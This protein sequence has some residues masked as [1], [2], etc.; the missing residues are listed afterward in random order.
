MADIKELSEQ[1]TKL[2]ASIDERVTKANAT[3]ADAGK[4]AEDLKGELKNLVE[5]HNEVQRA[6]D[7]E[8][9]L[10]KKAVED[11]KAQL[12]EQQTQLNE[13][14]VRL[15]KA[16]KSKGKIDTLTKFNDA[17]ERE[18]NEKK[19]EIE[20]IRTIKGSVSLDIQDVTIKDIVS[21]STNTGLNSLLPSDRPTL[22]GP[23]RRTH[24]RDFMQ[25]GRTS[26]DSFPYIEE[27]A[28]NA[29][30]GFVGETE[31]P[32]KDDLQI[33]NKSAP[34]KK[35]V[36]TMDLSDEIIA[37]V[38]GMQTYAQGRMLQKYLLSEDAGI[39]KGAGTGNTLTGLF[40]R[41][42]AFAKVGDDIAGATRLDIL[43]KAVAL[44]ANREY[45]ATRALIHDVD[46]IDMG[47]MKDDNSRYMTEYL[48]TE[49]T[50]AMRL[51]QI[52]PTTVMT[53]GEFLVGD[54][55]LGVE[56]IDREQFSIQLSTENNDN[57]ERGLVTMKI[58]GRLALP[59]YFPQA[60]VKGTFAA[61][62]TALAATA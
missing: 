35:I 43:A 6:L 14:N 2:S 29:N 30:G 52:V 61:A 33:E 31:K 53:I 32:V 36:H 59:V 7:S 5:K 50:G 49:P 58:V 26:R 45:V 40:T 23:D 46:Y 20:A 55:A 15:Q 17:I 8:K 22:H 16:E 3:A 47:L 9:D 25:I 19:E 54:F 1:I 48:F 42:S 21:F 24:M 34:V 38:P 4:V 12:A 57:F 62:Q 18:Y 56:L 39:L 10:A 44:T 60:F 51:I 27:T 41:A 37:D 11:L 13:Q 28:Y